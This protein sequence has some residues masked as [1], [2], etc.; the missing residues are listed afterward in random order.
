[1]RRLLRGGVLMAVANMAWKNRA[2]IERA[3]RSQTQGRRR[4]AGDR[5]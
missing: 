3:V 5:R 1:M 2:Q 4:P